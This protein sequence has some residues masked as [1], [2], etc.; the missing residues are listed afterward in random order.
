[1]DPTTII[2]I[3]LTAFI[4]YRLY[5]VLGAKTGEEKPRD[6]EGLQRAARRE[7]VEEPKAAEPEP[8]R[9]LPPVSAPAEPLRAADPQFDERAFI[10]GAKGAYEM[11]VE[12]FASGDLKSIRRFLAPGVFDAFKTAVT[13]RESAGQRY[14]LKFVGIESAKIASAKVEGGDMIAVAE[15]LSNQV[16]TTYDR[17]GGVISGDPNRIDLVRD[18]WTFSRALNAT[19]PNWTLIATGA[20]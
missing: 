7:P 13:A 18:R 20:S 4:V 2:F 11:I 14:D 10:E 12:A 17:G 5:T 9:P 19:D 16:R 3:A 8:H 15:F 1:M 6:I